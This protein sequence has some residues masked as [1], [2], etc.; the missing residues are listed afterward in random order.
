M[1]N[2]NMSAV[3]FTLTELAN[4]HD[5]KISYCH[6]DVS[7]STIVRFHTNNGALFGQIIVMN[8][9]AYNSAFPATY[10]RS[11]FRQILKQR[12]KEEE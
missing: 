10:A 9:H 5:C 1:N 3:I 2:D 6:D 8:E 12:E 11:L 4:E 7:M